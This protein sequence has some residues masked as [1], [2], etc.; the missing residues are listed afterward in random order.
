MNKRHLLTILIVGQLSVNT[1]CFRES[2]IEVLPVTTTQTTSDNTE[3][4]VKGTDASARRGDYILQNSQIQVVING[5]LHGSSRDLL[6]PHSGGAIIDIA[7]QY[8]AGGN[9]KV[10]PRDDDG[11]NQL[12]QAVNMNRNTPIGYDTIRL[13]SVDERNASITLSGG[14]YDLDG[15]MAA[16]GATVDGKGRVVGCLVTTTYT[17]A[18]VV[19]TQSDDP[20]ALDLAVK[21]LS[22]STVVANLGQS[23][24]PVY[25]VNDMVFTSLGSAEIWVPYPDWGYEQPSAE[26]VAWPHFVQIQPRQINTTHYGYTSPL[27]GLLKVKREQNIALRNEITYVGKVGMPSGGIAAGEQVTFLRDFMAASSGSGGRSSYSPALMYRDM[28]NLLLDPVDPANL[29]N[30]LGRGTVNTSSGD[31]RDRYEG[32]IQ[33]EYINQSVKYFNG[34]AYVPLE[35]ERSYPIFGSSP[36]SISYSLPLPPGQMAL[37]AQGLNSE[38]YYQD[39]VTRLV[40][41]SDGAPIPDPDD[42]DTNLMETVPIILVEEEDLSDPQSVSFGFQRV[43]D[44]HYSVSLSADNDKARDVFTRI[45]MERIDEGEPLV[46]SLFPYDRQGAIFYLDQTTSASS[47]SSSHVDLPSGIFDLL[48]TR[49]PLNNVNIIRVNTSEEPPEDNEDPQFNR[50]FSIEQGSAL[51]LTGYLSADFDVRGASDPMG[52]VTELQLMLLAYAE[53]LDVLFF[54]NTNSQSAY[55]ELF[56]AQGRTAGEFDAADADNNV[57][58]WFDEL[59]YSRAAATIGKLGGPTGDRGRYALL[60]LPSEEQLD[61]FE[62][63]LMETNPATY[64]DRV[65]AISEEIVIHVTRPRAPKGFETGL[66]TAIAEMSGLPSGSA[67]PAEDPHYYQT[68]HSGTGTRLIDFDLLQ[69]L[70]GNHYDEYLLARKDWFNLLNA[71]IFRPATGGSS[72]GQ[73]SEIALGAVRSF[74][75]VTE[76]ALRDNDLVD[77]W[78]SAKAGRMFTTNGP[79]I[80]ATIN[81]ASYGEH[82]QVSGTVVQ[83]QV[84]VRAAYWVPVKE[85]RV[86]VDG[87]IVHTQTIETLEILRFDETIEIPLPDDGGSHWVVFE[88]GVRLDQLA[89]GIADTGTFGRVMPGHMPLGFTNPIFLD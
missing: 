37:R 55:A 70:S 35:E 67:I 57:D 9:R 62:V 64:I 32:H 88:A 17:L 63:P 19:E 73:T 79:I 50:A 86:I 34:S 11:L 26:S 81:G 49:G 77:F 46:I 33:F 13:D 82:S 5:D 21:W 12:S 3:T 83:A 52:M 22:M 84:R 61:Y 60:N 47:N 6:V 58:S 51:E 20:N 24:L 68:G 71:G 72:T 30:A 66:F 23:T 15:T 18:D 53:D 54:A 89:T 38:P 56:Q 36:I 48:V 10:T 41:D 2:G 80:E 85:L 1:G 44:T 87:Q 14:I 16:N 25:D 31:L 69:L 28:L 27:D 39:T 40:L 78:S 29:F 4:L 7:T 65:R 74:V 43:V 42:P 75:A 76:T 59:A 8:E 45:K